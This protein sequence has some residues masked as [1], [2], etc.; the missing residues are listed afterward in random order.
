[1]ADVA[2]V[3]HLQGI[4]FAGGYEAKGVTADV[5]VRDGLFNLRH[6][7]TDAFVS[8][9]SCRMM[10]MR[11]YCRCVRPIRRVRAVTFQAHHVCWLQKV[12]IVVRPV[13]VV[14]AETAHAVR[15]H[16]ALHKVVTLH[17]VL[18]RGSVREVGKRL[19]SQL[20]LF[21]LPVIP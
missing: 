12:R 21:E 13:N 1:M 9:T 19:L 17:A 20:V 16:G 2:G 4:G 15:V 10:S 8:R 14:A 18:V 3:G 6:V 7:A 5:D 11:F